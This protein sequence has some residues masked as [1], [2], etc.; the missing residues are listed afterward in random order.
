MPAGPS[1]SLR[2]KLVHIDSY[3]AMNGISRF[4]ENDQFR[5]A[6]WLFHG[7]KFTHVKDTHIL[8]LSTVHRMQTADL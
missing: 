6:N 4:L 8:C 7:Y 5:Y 2:G 3:A 1:K